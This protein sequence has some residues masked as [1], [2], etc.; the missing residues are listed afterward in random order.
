LNLPANPRFP[1]EEPTKIKASQRD[2][3]LRVNQGFQDEKENGN[4]RDAFQPLQSAPGLK[5]V[6]FQSGWWLL[7]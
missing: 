5:P 6:S 3:S 2:S 4:G 7:R 1:A